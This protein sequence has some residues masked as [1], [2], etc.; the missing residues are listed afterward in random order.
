MVVVFYFLNFFLV[1]PA[2]LMSPVL[3]RSMVAGSGTG[4]ISPSRTAHHY[5]LDQTNPIQY[6]LATT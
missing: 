1:V 6:V 2:R 5:P 3:R 4:A